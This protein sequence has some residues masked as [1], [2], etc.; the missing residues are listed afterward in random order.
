MIVAKK[1]TKVYTTAAKN[2]R[3]NVV[4]ALETSRLATRVRIR[5]VARLLARLK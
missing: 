1:N 2:V 3:V 5:L 4:Q